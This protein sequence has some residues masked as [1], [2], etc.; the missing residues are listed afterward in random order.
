MN[1]AKTL[2][3]SIQGKSIK[4][5]LK[6][7]IRFY[8]LKI[9]SRPKDLIF[10][11]SLLIPKTESIYDFIYVRKNLMGTWTTWAS[12]IESQA[13]ENVISRTEQIITTSETVRQTFFINKLLE[14]KKMV[15]LVGPTGIYEVYNKISQISQID[16]NLRRLFFNNFWRK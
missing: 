16:I 3:K 4:F 8:N 9:I 11:K 1:Y 13:L 7:I 12:L 14:M 5:N 2:I 10:S 6:L 15:L